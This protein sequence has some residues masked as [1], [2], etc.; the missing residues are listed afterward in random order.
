MLFSLTLVSLMLPLCLAAQAGT[1]PSWEHYKSLFLAGDGRV[2]DYGQQ[3]SSTSESQGYG[4]LLA[5]F[6]DD[7]KAFD[8]IWNWSRSNLS[9]RKDSLMAWLWGKRPNDKWEVMDYNNAT[10][11]DILISFAL[12]KAARQWNSANYRQEAIPIVRSLRE[13]L[14]VVHE[15]DTFILPGYYG[16]TNN[17][18][19]T[20]NP[21]YLIF[22]A[23][24]LF[25]E[26]DEPAFWKGVYR[27]AIELLHNSCLGTPCLPADWVRLEGKSIRMDET[28]STMFSYDAIRTLLHLSWEDKPM[29]GGLSRV[30]DFYAQRG[31]IPEW[32]DLRTDAMSDRR[33]HAGVYAVYGLAARLSGNTETGKKLLYEARDNIMK[34]ERNYYSY[35]LYLL[36]LIEE[37]I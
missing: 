13:Q 23:Y 35:S 15:G 9:V 34:E 7:R 30:F 29:P 2:I 21:S 8:T 16:F 3:H 26:V 20:L 37:P 31:F 18:N 22:P 27:S 25:A 32:V 14:A 17:G 33:A 11:G 19:V 4:M 6:N 24:R 28:R 5:V 36:S 1:G 12:L 10:D